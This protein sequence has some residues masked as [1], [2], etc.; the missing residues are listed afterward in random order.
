MFEFTASYWSQHRNNPQKFFSFNIGR[1]VKHVSPGG[2]LVH[3]CCNKASLTWAKLTWWRH[4]CC[5]GIFLFWGSFHL[6]D[7]WLWVDS[8][9][10]KMAFESQQVLSVVFPQRV[11]CTRRRTNTQ[12]TRD[13][14][15]GL[16]L[17]DLYPNTERIANIRSPKLHPATRHYPARS[18]TIYTKL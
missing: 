14:L 7:D 10:V 9:T 3:R 2:H 6:V 13:V 17:R 1:G 18:P 16:V 11:R 8:A 4:R 5:L 15:P 12:Q